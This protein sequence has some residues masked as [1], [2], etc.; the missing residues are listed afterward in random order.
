MIKKITIF[1]IL[2][3][4]LSNCQ[5]LKE[6]LSMKKKQGVDEFLIEKKNPLVLP[7][8]YSE[9]PKPKSDEILEDNKNIDL[10][11]VLNNKEN[12]DEVNISSDLEKSI[13]NI[14]NKK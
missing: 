6:N 11:G 14:L 4:F 5:S 13:S 2:L 3:V 8:N 9:L 1:L 10:T 7:P 12:A